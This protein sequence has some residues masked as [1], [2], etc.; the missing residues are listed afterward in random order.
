MARTVNDIIRTYML[1]SENKQQVGYAQLREAVRVSWYKLFKKTKE[2]F[3]RKWVS[4]GENGILPYPSEAENILGVFTVDECN[5]LQPLIEDNHKN[6]LP[7]PEKKCGCNKCECNGCVCGYIEDSIS[8]E[9][10]LIEGQVYTNTIYTRVL[11]NGQIVEESEIWA[12]SYDDNG[13]FIRA[14]KNKKQ[15]TICELEK[16]EDCGC[17]VDCEENTE[18]LCGCGCYKTNCVPYIRERYPSLYSKYGYYKKDEINRKIYIFDN[19]GEVSK[20]ENVIV[21]FQG[22]GEGMLVPDYAEE[23]LIALLDWTKKQY[24]P[25]YTDM[26]AVLAKKNYNRAKNEMMRYLFPIPY[27]WVVQGEVSYIDKNRKY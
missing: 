13:H 10:V 22:T 21:L 9:D 5:E 23:A 19:C 12:A 26:Q 14:E 1:L 3:Q 18:K 7:L 24:S 25:V 27:E 4:V 11:S 16:E 15:R 20:V 8:I 6:I 2:S 17:I